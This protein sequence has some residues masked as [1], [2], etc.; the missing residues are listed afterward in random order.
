MIISGQDFI[1]PSKSS[2]F[3]FVIFRAFPAIATA[4]LCL[5]LMA[6]CKKDL[7]HP[8]SISRLQTPTSNR[9]NKILFVNDLLGF[10]VGGSRFDEADILITKDGGFTWSIYISPDAHKELFGIT[11]SPAG[12]IYAIGFEGNLLRSYDGGNTWL[13][14]QLRYEAYKALAFRDATHIECVGGISFD[15]GDVMYIDSAGQINGHDSLGYELNAI[16]IGRDGLGYRCGYGAMQ[17]TSDGGQNWL[18]STLK[19][20]NYTAIDVRNATSAFTC[21]AEGSICVTHNAGRDWE[22]LR[23]GND[24]S[25]PKYRLQDLLFINDLQGY[26]V[27]E[28]GLVIY[29]DD[30]GNHW[31]EVS[32]FTDANLH[33]LTRCPNGDLIVCGEG[34]ELWRIQ[35]H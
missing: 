22:T 27:G 25:H 33:G 19:N 13:H 20:D 5:M 4:T 17:Y 32:H 12:A 30:A 26:A 8:Q 9:L 15:R 29:T 21:G 28:S 7:I 24:L 2:L 11:Q 35:I 6:S 16:K 10:C 23:N 1:I 31:S 3:Y 18:W 34:G 14:D